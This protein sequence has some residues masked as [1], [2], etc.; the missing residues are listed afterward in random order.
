M[1]EAILSDKKIQRKKPV[2][3]TKANQRSGPRT[4]RSELSRQRIIDAVIALVS[5]GHPRFGAVDIAKEAQIGLRTVFNH[6]EDMDSLYREMDAQVHQRIVLPIVLRPY[7][8]TKWQDLVLEVAERRA[9][10]FE[11]GYYAAKFA[12]MMRANSS[13]LS[14]GVERS[15]SLERSGVEAIVPKD[16]E[17]RTLLVLALDAAFGF[18]NWVRLRE[19]SDLSVED[20]TKVLKYTAQG[21]IRQHTS[22]HPEA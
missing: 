18:D 16:V 1:K 12:R 8:A 5:K 14:D 13:A 17:G 11:A 7:E 20:A 6:F 10:I 15:I 4:S 22:L 3:R 2:R 9:E 21:L 19:G